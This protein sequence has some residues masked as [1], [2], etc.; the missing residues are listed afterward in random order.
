MTRD[1]RVSVEAQRHLGL[2]KRTLES[3]LTGTIKILESMGPDAT[4][5][6]SQLLPEALIE[7]FNITTEIIAQIE[8]KL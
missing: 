8:N 6:E 4:K 7:S 2:Q 3:S 1:S 5:Q